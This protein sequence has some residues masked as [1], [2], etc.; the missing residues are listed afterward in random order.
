[1]HLPP[2]RPIDLLN[3]AF[4]NPRSLQ[5]ETT[6]GDGLAGRSSDAREYDVPDRKT[7]R[8]SWA[9]L[10]RLAPERTW[11]FVEIDVPHAEFTRMRPTIEALMAPSESVMD[12][13]IG[14]A[15]YFAS[16]GRGS[17]RQAHGGGASEPYTTPARV[18]LS[19][20]GA[21]ELLGGYS[22]HRRAFERS[23]P[24]SDGPMAALVAELQ[25]DLDRLPT[26]NLG[27]DDRVLSASG[28]EAR[29][30][31]LAHGVVHYLASLPVGAKMDLHRPPGFG[32]KMLLRRIAAAHLGLLR[33]ST[34]TKRAIQFGARSAKMDSGGGRVKGHERLGGGG[35][36]NSVQVAALEGNAQDES[37][38]G[39]GQS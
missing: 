27:R 4:E 34:L 13:S 3:V 19:G 9:E 10:Q 24:S 18:L 16:R 7:G 29:Y 5:S 11:R 6:S 31:F 15:L 36:A 14:A 22:R 12:L 33:A 39:K 1:M 26:R 35:A 28:R 2:G 20:L 37:G 25:L 32:D 17:I 23:A 21:D 30:P 8:A 38:G